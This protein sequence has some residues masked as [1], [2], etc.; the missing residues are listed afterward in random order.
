MQTVRKW[1][2]RGPV[3]VLAVALLAVRAPAA[4]NRAR[5]RAPEAEERLRRDVEF[6]AAD[7]CEGRGP[8]TRGINK[9]ADHIAAELKKAGLKPGGQGGSYFQHFTMPGARLLRPATLTL[10]G[11][12]GQEVRLAPGTDFH[13]MGLSYTGAYKDVPVVFAG[14]GADAGSKDFKYSDFDGLDVAGKVVVVLRDA[15]GAGNRFASFDGQNR[16]KHASLTQKMLN[17]EKRDALG[18]LFVNDADT[19]KDGDD[20]LDFGYSSASVRIMDVPKVPA[21]HVRRHVLEKLLSGSGA[22]ALEAIERRIDREL[23][24]ASFPLTGWTVSF[25]VQVKRDTIDLKN[26]VGVLEGKGPR[27]DETV[28]VGAHY[29]H[30]G[31]GGPNSLSGS[32]KMAIHNGADDNASGTAALIELARRFARDPQRQGRRVVFIAFSGEE[33]GLLG[34]NY[35]CKHPPFAHAGTAAMVNLDMVGRVVKDDKSGLEKLQVHGVGTSKGFAD[36]IDR[37]NANYNFALRKVASGFGPSDHSSFYAKKVPVFFLFTGDHPDYH[38]PGDDSHKI[39][40][41]GLRRVTDLTEDL[42]AYLA[43]V[44]QKPEYVEV[45]DGRAGPRPGGRPGIRLGIRPEYGD[46][47]PGVLVGGVSAGD[48]AARAGIKEGDRIV[49]M[50]GKPIK[51]LEGYMI[52]L[53]TQKQGNTID[54]GLLRD[55]KKIGLKVK[56]D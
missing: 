19:A 47:E 32:K 55:G 41:G 46:D 23:K 40:Y 10:R 54:V 29:D 18:V 4:E 50:N 25:D 2:V 3:L 24:P 31:Y 22:P 11:P 14:Y 8:A 36:A 9:A 17:A 44:P 15:P 28:V 42:V 43:T 39:N 48:P 21:F 20:L 33:L 53:G 45:K 5:E 27:A 35:Y 12:L 13:P 30:L 37:L 26:V 6:L 1:L 56:L 51:N 16:R 7:E 34:S 49:E 52:F 38:R